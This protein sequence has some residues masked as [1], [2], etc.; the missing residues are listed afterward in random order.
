MDKNM[1]IGGGVIAVAG[2]LGIFAV[3]KIVKKFKPEK[4]EKTQMQMLTEMRD[5]IHK[6]EEVLNEEEA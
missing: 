4:Q 2:T 1:I 3:K 5:D 6:D